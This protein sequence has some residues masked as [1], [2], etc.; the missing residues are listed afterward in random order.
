MYVTI[1][2][3]GSSSTTSAS[4][5]PSSLSAGATVGTSLGLGGVGLVAG[6]L[7]ALLA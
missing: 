2:Q 5:K 7:G 4:S 3:T 6:V 1:T